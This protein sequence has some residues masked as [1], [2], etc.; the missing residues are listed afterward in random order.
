MLKIY[1]IDASKLKVIEE[2]KSW[3]FTLVNKKK[4]K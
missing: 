4:A 3:P 2:D 1:P